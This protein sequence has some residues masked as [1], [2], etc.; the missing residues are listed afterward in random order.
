MKK[1][2]TNTNAT[3]KSTCDPR[4]IYNMNHII[5][6][7]GVHPSDEVYFT[8]EGVLSK[9]PHV[10]KLE[11]E[12]I[13]T[14]LKAGYTNQKVCEMTCRSADTIHKIKKEAGLTK[15][16]KANNKFSKVII[17]MYLHGM[18]PMEIAGILEMEVFEVYSVINKHNSVS[19]S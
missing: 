16:R 10:G 5:C 19:A 13:V 12:K 4:A 8:K 18:N 6:K 9:R 3:M 2:T 11:R 17:A 7:D 14:L 1:M 15:P